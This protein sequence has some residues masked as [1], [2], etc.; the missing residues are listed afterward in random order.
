MP[1]FT[2]KAKAGT[3]IRNPDGRVMRR[4]EREFTTAAAGALA[5]LLDALTDNIGDD[6]NMM[7]VRL[8]DGEVTRPF[9]DAITGE[10][11]RV[12]LAGSEFGREQIEGDVFGVRKAS[13]IEFG[14]WDL[15][16]ARA[17][18]WALTYGYELIRGILDTTRGY[19]QSAVSDYIQSRMTIGELIERIRGGGM[20]SPE[21]AQRIAV[22]EVTRAFAS[23]NMAAWRASGV[24]EAREWRTNNDELVCPVCGPLAGRVAG[25]DE[26]F[27]VGISGPPAHPRCR[28]WIVPKVV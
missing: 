16:N 27:D 4:M 15:A 9:H 8:D 6:A 19:L 25:L 10:L 21:R 5:A 11:Q 26:E 1:P 12:A 18:E 7:L 17:A 22:T 14:V 28:C 2:V 13:P 20:F 24:I 3:I 23:G